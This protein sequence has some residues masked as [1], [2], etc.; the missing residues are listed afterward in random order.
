VKSAV[1]ED[2]TLFSQEEAGAFAF[3]GDRLVTA[4]GLGITY[5]DIR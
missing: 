1:H 3:V 2:G 4:N 5:F